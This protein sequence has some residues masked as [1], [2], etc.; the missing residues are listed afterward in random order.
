MYIKWQR[1]KRQEQGLRSP[2]IGSLLSVNN[3]FWGERNA[4]IGVFLVTLIKFLPPKNE[5]KPRKPLLPPD[6]YIEYQHFS[7]YPLQCGH[8]V[9]G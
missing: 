1:R 6:K 4:V 7:K 5:A 2:K 3:Q 8:K 9:I